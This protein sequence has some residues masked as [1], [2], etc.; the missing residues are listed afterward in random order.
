MDTHQAEIDLTPQP[1][2]LPGKGEQMSNQ[3]RVKR[4]GMTW[5]STILAFFPGLMM[6]LVGGSFL[7]VCLSPGIGAVLL[8]LFSLYGLPLL[9]YRIHAR[10]Y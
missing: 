8:L 3:M 5:L 4:Q 6:L 1:P 7:W 10:F 2:S 9:I